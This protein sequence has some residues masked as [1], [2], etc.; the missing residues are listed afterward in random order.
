[1]RDHKKASE[2]SPKASVGMQMSTLIKRRKKHD[3]D[4]K[5]VLHI[6]V[7]SARIDFRRMW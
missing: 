3:D 4:Y 1:M 2:S 6:R 7:D 5:A